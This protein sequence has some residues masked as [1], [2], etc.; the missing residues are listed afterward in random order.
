MVEDEIL[1]TDNVRLRLIKAGFRI[2]NID[3]YL[4]STRWPI[5]KARRTILV[6]SFL[7]S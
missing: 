6:P 4:V 3:I 7:T 5:K 2:N 1:V